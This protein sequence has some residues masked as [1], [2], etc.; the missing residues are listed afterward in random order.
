MKKLISAFLFSTFTM[1]AFSQDLSILDY[2][3][4]IMTD[5]AKKGYTKEALFAQMNRDLIKPGASICSNRALV[6]VYDFKRKQNIDSAKI[7]MFYTKKTGEVGATTWWYHVSPMVNEN[8]IAWVM[9]AGFGRS[10]P[11]P[12]AK[13]DWL[14]KFAGSTNCKEIQAGENDLIEKMF[15]GRVFPETTSYGTFD[16]YYKIVPAGYWTPASVA[17]NLLGVD[18]E[19]NPTNF[20]RDEI[21]HGDLMSACVEAVTTSP[22][23][24]VLSGP[25]RCKKYLGL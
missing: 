8:G 9:D 23:G 10:I 20:V 15:Q 1:A 5:I 25:S 3:N 19:G 14:K 16:C 11:G 13:N 7:F 18:M 2:P 24:R 6:W 22:I 12:L 21:D 17:M 4:A